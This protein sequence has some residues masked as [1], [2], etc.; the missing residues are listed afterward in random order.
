MA[1]AIASGSQKWKGSCADLVNAETATSTATGTVSSGRCDQK[2]LAR[3][4][5]RLVVPAAVAATDTAA[6]RVSPPMNVRMR[7]R[8]EPASPPEPERAMS[9][10]DASDTSSQARNRITTSSARTRSRIDS[11]NAVMM[12]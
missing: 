10:K 2:S 12:V 6:S 5:C 1:A 7:V 11:V 9:M 3:I 4:S 8:T